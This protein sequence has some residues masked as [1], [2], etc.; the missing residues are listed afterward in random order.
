MPLAALTGN[1]DAASVG[2]IEA[3]THFGDKSAIR[4]RPHVGAKALVLLNRD[5]AGKYSIPDTPVDYFPADDH[6]NHPAYFATIGFDNEDVDK[7]IENLRALRAKD[8]EAMEKK[9]AEA[10]ANPAKK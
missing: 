4:E 3:E 6:G 7:V 10:R 2:E 5:E 8:R 9:E 1:L